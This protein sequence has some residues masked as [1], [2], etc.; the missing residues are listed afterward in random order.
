MK[1]QIQELIKKGRLS[2]AIDLLVKE[3]R[4]REYEEVEEQIIELS[5]QLST[6]IRNRNLGLIGYQEAQQIEIRVSFAI[7][8]IVSELNW[9]GENLVKSA[10]K[11]A[12]FIGESQPV[13]KKVVLF[14]GSN[15]S[16]LAQLQLEKEFV[17]IS[18]RLQNNTDQFELRAEW[19]VNG[20]ELQEAILTHKPDII[21]FAGHGGWEQA[22]NSY[23]D[24]NNRSLVGLFMNDPDT[25]NAALVSG[26]AIGELFGI[27][28]KN[29][30]AIRFS[31][32]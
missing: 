5:R 24:G 19:T 6:T 8:G 29:N 4:K 16:D 9:G 15:P 3:A 23:D 13:K 31:Y 30:T 20:K 10:E 2:E 1:Q 11:P 28:K 14:L 17:Q 18:K 27:V 21:H 22:P 12:A 25:K 7:Q 26:E 32:F